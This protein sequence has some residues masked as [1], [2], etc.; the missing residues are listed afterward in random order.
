MFRDWRNYKCLL[1]HR[2]STSVT[3]DIQP[4]GVCSPCVDAKANIVILS[5]AAVC[6]WSSD[7][8]S[9]RRLVSYVILRTVCVTVAD[10]NSIPRFHRWYAARSAS[11]DFSPAERKPRP[12]SAVLERSDRMMAW[13]HGCSSG[14]E[15]V[16]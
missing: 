6:T 1:A 16:A 4:E 14:L 2:I 9:V 10:L 13:P 7:E 8:L 11:T 5:T 15:L 12:A 3:I